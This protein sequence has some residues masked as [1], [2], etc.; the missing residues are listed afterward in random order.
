M[1]AV[2]GTVERANARQ[3]SVAC[4]IERQT[5]RRDAAAFVPRITSR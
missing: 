2:N 5:P 3:V 1:G 4:H